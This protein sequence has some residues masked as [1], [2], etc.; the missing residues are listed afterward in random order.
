MA[1][2]PRTILAGRKVRVLVVDDSAVIRR[3]I[4]SAL[5]GD[6]DLEL[7]GTAANGLIALQRI[8]QLNPDVITLDIEMPEL[9]GIETLRR[10]RAQYPSLPVIMCS[11]LTERGAAITIDALLMGANDYLTKDVRVTA[12][13]TAAENF[14]EHLLPKLKQFFQLP[15]RPFAVVPNS[16]LPPQAAKGGTPFLI[17]SLVSTALVL[18]RKVLV[19]GVSTGG[20]NALGEILPTIPANFPLPILITQ[21]MP[22][23]FTKLFAERLNVQCEVQVEEASN[24]R[25]LEPGLVLIAPGDY[26]LGLE[27]YDSRVRVKLNQDSPENSCRPAVDV[28][29]RAANDTFKGA[30]I[31]VILTGMGQDGLRGCELLKTSGAHILAQDE[32]SSVVWGMPGFIARAGLADRVLPLTNIVPEILAETQREKAGLQ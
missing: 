14:R 11:T 9:N 32:A 8:P 2:S 17:R 16:P 22:P 27:R 23:M 1:T 29:F 25:L 30:V 15:S 13:G 21:H 20:P 12:S 18:P 4:G 26:H 28:M 19:V 24:G 31:A 10:I 5:E 6:P 7:V 3:L